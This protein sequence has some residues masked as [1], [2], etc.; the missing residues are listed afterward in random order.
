MRRSPLRADRSRLRK[1]A[2]VTLP[3][4]PK[5]PLTPTS[6]RLLESPARS[7]PT[8]PSKR[9]TQSAPWRKQAPTS[10]DARSQCR[11]PGLRLTCRPKIRWQRG[12]SKRCAPP[13]A[14]SSFAVSTT[15][16]FDGSSWK[17]A[18]ASLRSRP[19]R[20]HANS[21]LSSRSPSC[22]LRRVRLTARHSPLTRRGLTSSHSL[23]APR[24]RTPSRHSPQRCHRP[25]KNDR[26]MLRTFR[27]RW[28]RSQVRPSRQVAW[29]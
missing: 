29:A 27:G 16:A 20:T 2:E 14:T 11:T 15:T 26:S 13:S 12:R 10:R 22:A 6:P 5:T 17:K 8:T 1:S 9:G 21:S 25:W 28:D 19:S 4:G 18:R 24:Q 7:L 3:S 23:A